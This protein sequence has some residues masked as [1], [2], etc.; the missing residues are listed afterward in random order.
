MEHLFIH[1]NGSVTINVSIIC[2]LSLAALFQESAL[3]L[4]SP[5]ARG[6]LVG[7]TLVAQMY[8]RDLQYYNFQCICECAYTCARMQ[9]HIS[10]DLRQTFALL[11]IPVM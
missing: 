7:F 1:L 5:S 9:V 11:S 2:P 6:V 3:L 10:V 4:V 8:R